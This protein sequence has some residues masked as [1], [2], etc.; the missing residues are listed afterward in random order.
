MKRGRDLENEIRAR[1]QIQKIAENLTSTWFVK[2]EI[3]ILP[4][5]IHDKE[6]VLYFTSGRLEDK[7]ADSAIIALTNK[8]IIFYD[9]MPFTVSQ[10]YDIALT[11]INKVHWQV[12][13]VN[14]KIIIEYDNGVEKVNNVIKDEAE[15]FCRLASKVVTESLEKPVVKEN[16]NKKTLSKK[17]NTDFIKIE[18][19]YIRKHSVIEVEIVNDFSL[20]ITTSKVFNGT[21]FQVLKHFCNKQDMIS[22][23]EELEIY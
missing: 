10:E 4:K 1:N 17:S 21:S 12:D 15:T 14:T 20:M 8:R 3:N 5:L 6:D 7:K 19:R 9:D 11:E 18:Q 13:S 2:N 23:L 22:F 16:Q